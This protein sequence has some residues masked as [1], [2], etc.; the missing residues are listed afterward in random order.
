MLLFNK[1]TFWTTLNSALTHLSFT[2][3]H[4]ISKLHI[5]C[6]NGF[7]VPNG[8]RNAYI[9]GRGIEGKGSVC[10]QGSEIGDRGVAFSRRAAREAP[11]GCTDSIQRIANTLF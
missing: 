6:F 1:I 3:N 11:V 2:T 8:N 5:L 10:H 4:T 7:F 9:L